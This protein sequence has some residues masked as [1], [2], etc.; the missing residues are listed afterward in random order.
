[1]TAPALSRV[2]QAVLGILESCPGEEV[3][4]RDLRGLLRIR[5]FRRSAPALVFTLLGLEDKGLVT[6][7]EEVRVVE[8]VEIRDRYYSALR[9]GGM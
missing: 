2:E 1:V 3:S 6:C 8:G 4:G 5:G 9:A 7:R